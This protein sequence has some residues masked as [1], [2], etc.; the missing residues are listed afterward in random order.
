MLKN[1]NFYVF[2]S[3]FIKIVY[4]IS[5]ILVNI[6]IRMNI[7]KGIVQTFFRKGW[8]NPHTLPVSALA[9]DQ[10]DRQ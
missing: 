10:K 7:Q 1:I 5:S 9:A 4:S 8:T 2:I 3:K 6:K